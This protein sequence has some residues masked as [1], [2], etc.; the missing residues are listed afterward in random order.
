[1]KIPAKPVSSKGY[2]RYS[3]MEKRPP[4]LTFF[5]LTGSAYVLA[6]DKKTCR[7]RAGQHDLLAVARLS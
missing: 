3:S 4:N 5:S 1:M 6:Y 2:V 7:V